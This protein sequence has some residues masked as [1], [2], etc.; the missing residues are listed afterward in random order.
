[1]TNYACNICKE[2][3]RAPVVT[4]CGHL[5]CWICLSEWFNNSANGGLSC[6]TCFR[7]INTKNEVISIFTT[8]NED[9]RNQTY[10]IPRPSNTYR[11]K[12]DFL[13]P[14]V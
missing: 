12:Y 8:T 10:K 13:I 1:M 6:P 7:K 2:E 9:E 14:S 5:F 3:A 11:S 4:L